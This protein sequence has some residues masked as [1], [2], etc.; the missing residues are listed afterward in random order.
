M[1]PVLIYSPAYH[2]MSAGVRACHLLCDLLRK[3]GIDAAMRITH[4]TWMPSPYDAPPVQTLTQRQIN[5]SICIFPEYITHTNVT[6]PR[7]IKWWLQKPQERLNLKGPVF[8]WSKGMGKHPRL[9]LDVLDTNLFRPSSMHRGVVAY[10]VGKGVK[11][12]KFLPP[13]AIEISRAY[14]T[15][16]NDLANLIGQL[17]HLVCFDGFSALSCEAALM[18]TPVLMPNI[19]KDIRKLNEAHEFEIKPERGF[20]YNEAQMSVA[21]A[22]VGTFYDFYKSLKPM[23]ERDLFDFVDMLRVKW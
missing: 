6:T 10:Y 7:A 16:R 11:D 20:A 3:N 2:H 12:D 17:D 9:M 15:D 19:S 8:V 5:E 22:S 4:G 13:N 1:R 21:R 18:G 14:P 23:F